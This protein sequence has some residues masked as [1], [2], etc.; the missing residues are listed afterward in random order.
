MSHNESKTLLLSIQMMINDKVKVENMR[1]VKE[2]INHGLN[3]V[4]PL[5][6]DDYAK[7]GGPEVV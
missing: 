2:A 5:T 1:A 3:T 7:D 6:I 4:K